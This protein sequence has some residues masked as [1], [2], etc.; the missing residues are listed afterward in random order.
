MA[1]ELIPL[2]S[3]HAPMATVVPTIRAG[4]GSGRCGAECSRRRNSGTVNCADRRALCAVVS[5]VAWLSVYHLG[6][7]ANR[8]HQPVEA[9][10]PPVCR[11]RR[12]HAQRMTSTVA[13][14][15]A[16]AVAP[17][18]TVTPDG[19]DANPATVGLPGERCLV[20][21]LTR[22]ASSA[23]PSSLRMP[24][25]RRSR[26]LSPLSAV[27]R[28]PWR[29]CWAGAAS[30]AAAVAELD[31]TSVIPLAQLRERRRVLRD[32]LCHGHGLQMALL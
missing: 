13:R 28:I 11:C 24:R 18:T 10:T 3:T 21:R 12:T 19:L 6:L 2:H 1:R 4:R 16:R 8:V 25:R 23:F 9:P 15:D 30:A 22:R 20:E 14:A 5:P 32:Q 17:L 26:L 7:S 31:R 29:A 27:D